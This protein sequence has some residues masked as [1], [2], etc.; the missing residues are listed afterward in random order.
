M[1]QKKG[2]GR[3][4]APFIKY[5]FHIWISDEVWTL[6]VYALISYFIYSVFLLNCF[7][8]P[9]QK[10]LKTAFG[11]RGFSKS[12]ITKVILQTEMYLK[13]QRMMGGTGSG[14]GQM[15]IPDTPS[16]TRSLSLEGLPTSE[17]QSNIQMMSHT[18]T[19]KEVSSW[20]INSLYVSYA[21]CF[22]LKSQNCNYYI[23]MAENYHGCCN[24]NHN[25]KLFSSG[26]I[27]GLVSVIAV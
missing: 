16:L 15:N 8:V 1:Q 4:L 19:I 18:L 10:L 21:W 14:G 23:C 17:T 6:V 26:I 3:D 27:G 2:G 25:N 9:P 22:M 5:S 12:E 20:L 11:I 7:Q 24:F 13:S